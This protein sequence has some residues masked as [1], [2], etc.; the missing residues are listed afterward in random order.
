MFQYI[1][2]QLLSNGLAVCQPFDLQLPL[3][4]LAELSQQLRTRVMNLGEQKLQLA[5]TGREQAHQLNRQI[6]RD[7]IRWLTQENPAEKAWLDFMAQLQ[8]HL[9]RTLLLGLF[10]YECHFSHYRPGDFYQKHKDAFIGQSNRVLS[11]VLYLNPDWQADEGGE[12]LIYGDEEN[13]TVRS[14]LLPQF[15]TLVTFLSEEF[16]HE[17]LA[18]NRHRY[19]IAGWFRLNSSVSHR[20]DPPR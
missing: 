10:S 6:R 18:A 11:T 16:P 20:V 19:S 8:Q 13:D 3:T 1:E 14:R 5:G 12:L 9:N 7:R 15:G 2:E 4:P 17:V